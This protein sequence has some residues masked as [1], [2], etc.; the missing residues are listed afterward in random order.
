MAPDEKPNDL[1][2]SP[3][4]TRSLSHDD[5]VLGPG[6]MI[7]ARKTTGIPDEVIGV[8]VRSISHKSLD[9]SHICSKV[10]PQTLLKIAN[11]SMAGRVDLSGHFGTLLCP[12]PSNG[13]RTFVDGSERG[14]QGSGGWIRAD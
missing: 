10:D 9:I 11:G 7:D 13:S 1:A 4:R 5:L 14:R 6:L 2:G 3:F 8:L 12:C